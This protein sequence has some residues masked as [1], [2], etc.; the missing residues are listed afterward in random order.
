MVPVP[1]RLSREDGALRRYVTEE[2]PHGALENLAAETIALMTPGRHSMGRQT[3]NAPDT[4]IWAS[5]SACWTNLTDGTSK[6]YKLPDPRF[7]QWSL[8]FAFD[9][10]GRRLQNSGTMHSH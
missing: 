7:F 6:V 10:V 8:A 9:R 5:P 1:G 2:R 4:K 3:N